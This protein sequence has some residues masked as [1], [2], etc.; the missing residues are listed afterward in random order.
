[1]GPDPVPNKQ[2]DW[3]TTSK[4]SYRQS[5]PRFTTKLHENMFQFMDDNNNETLLPFVYQNRLKVITCF[6]WHI[7]YSWALDWQAAISCSAAVSFFIGSLP[8]K[9]G[10][11]ICT[12]L[13][14]A[15]VIK[16]ERLNSS[17]FGP[18][19][20]R[21]VP[22]RAVNACLCETLSKLLPEL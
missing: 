10:R 7:I 6:C 12:C 4:V 11:T 15:W 8:D 3:S 13:G 1:M 14:V 17:V 16:L 21:T 19:L 22:V 18:Y 20:L 5:S 2:S 9:E